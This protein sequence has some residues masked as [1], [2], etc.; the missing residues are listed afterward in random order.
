[1]AKKVHYYQV[2]DGEWV[3]VGMRNNRD[4]CCDCGLIHKVNYRITDKGKIEVQVF[5][6]A[7]ATNGARKNFKFEKET[8]D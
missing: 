5:R 3:P 1:M 4:Q 6:D 8:E 2:T 7:R